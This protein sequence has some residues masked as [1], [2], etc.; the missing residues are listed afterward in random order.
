MNIFTIQ[1]PLPHKEKTM[2]ISTQQIKAAVS[3]LADRIGIS[4]GYGSG[5]EAGTGERI[6]FLN[7]LP[8]PQYNCKTRS[9]F[10]GYIRG[11][12][13]GFEYGRTKNFIHDENMKTKLWLA[14]NLLKRFHRK[15]L[16]M[17]QSVE[18]DIFTDA[19]ECQEAVR[20][21]S[22]CSADLW[23]E[24]QRLPKHIRE[25]E[26]QEVQ[27]DEKRR[28]KELQAIQTVADLLDKHIGADDVQVGVHSE[29]EFVEDGAWVS[30][31]VW[32]PEYT[33]EDENDDR[34]RD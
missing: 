27:K 30:V 26:E 24:I 5:N 8:F 25:P 22:K 16:D 29:V 13:D 18:G 14:E 4:L 3:A 11:L 7:G 19:E 15:S 9:G 10:L 17:I 33:Y 2:P 6:L 28:E 1:N 32:A 21:V 31:R 20:D 12:G 34:N 23:A